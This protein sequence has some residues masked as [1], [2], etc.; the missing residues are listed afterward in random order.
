VLPCE[1]LDSPRLF[2]RVPGIFGGREDKVLMGR[3][4]KNHIEVP[5]QLEFW[6]QIN[7][8]PRKSLLTR[9]VNLGVALPKAA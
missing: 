6:P 9:R 2:R 8:K 7:G 4:F 1:I 3:T 5:C